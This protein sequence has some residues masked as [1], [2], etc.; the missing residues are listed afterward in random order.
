MKSINRQL[1]GYLA[2][3]NGRVCVGVAIAVVF[4]LSVSSMMF[5]ASVFFDYQ[6]A[7]NQRAEHNAN[8][9]VEAIDKSGPAH[10]S[11]ALA[12]AMGNKEIVAIEASVSGK[13]YAM[14]RNPQGEPTLT[15]GSVSPPNTIAVRKSL[16]RDK[17]DQNYLTLFQSN[18]KLR[19]SLHHLLVVA[20]VSTVSLS[21]IL[22]IVIYAILWLNVLHPLSIMKSQ[23]EKLKFQSLEENQSR[24]LEMPREF[25]LL[26]DAMN[27]M[28]NRLQEQIKETQEA[29]HR[30][31]LVTRKFPMPLGIYHP[32]TRK[33]EFINEQFTQTFGYL[34]ED[35]PH[36]DDWYEKAFPDPEYRNEVKAEWR[37]Q[38]QAGKEIISTIEPMDRK[39]QCKD[40]SIKYVRSGGIV[41]VDEFIV[42][43]FL[44]QTEQKLAQQAV[45]EHRGRLR[46]LTA[47]IQDVREEERKRV[48]QELHDELG[49]SL[50]VARIDLSNLVEKVPPDHHELLEGMKLQLQTLDNASDSARRLSEN[51]RPG[52][53]DLL[54][55]AAA[56]ELHAKRFTESTGIRVNLNMG[57]IDALELDD[58]VATTAF[59]IV[60]ES[61]TNVAKYAQA[62][63]VDIYVDKLEQEILLVIKDDGVGFDLHAQKQRRGFGLLGMYER[64]EML[65]GSASVE[66]QPGKGVRIEA[67]LPTGGKQS[68]D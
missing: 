63:K 57:D 31:K 15:S 42:G 25:K 26:C 61:L 66:T 24:F 21:V 33:T 32:S 12:L 29:N 13:H 54:G 6:S 45:V 62:S 68:H 55:L 19:S 17:P 11:E 65:G 60:Q 58:R 22:V 10:I 16:P 51:L 52:M 8:L 9:A 14:V 3:I 7:L 1:R 38:L 44:D 27:D 35:V 40:G 30:F 43:V 67:S 18:A 59:R 39:V 64:A 28:L 56:L 37:A 53:L 34:I 20:I 49:Q 4:V 36:L 41:V 5:Y 48:A 2:S 23:A 50:T 46:E 47:H